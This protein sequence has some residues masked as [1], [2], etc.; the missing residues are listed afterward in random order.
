VFHHPH[1]SIPEYAITKEDKWWPDVEKLKA[2]CGVEVWILY[3]NIQDP[4]I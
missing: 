1:L 2:S 4:I 3:K